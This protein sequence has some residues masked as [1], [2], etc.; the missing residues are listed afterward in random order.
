MGATLPWQLTTGFLEMR[1]SVARHVTR[2]PIFPRFEEH[3]R[4]TSRFPC[5]QSKVRMYLLKGVLSLPSL[6]RK[7]IRDAGRA[8]CLMPNEH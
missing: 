6:T 1:V 4:A 7:G 5:T 3:L 2:F 8:R